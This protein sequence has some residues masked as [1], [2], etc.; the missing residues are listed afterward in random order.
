MLPPPSEKKATELELEMNLNKIRDV[1]SSGLV[2][3]VRALPK[4]ELHLHMDG[5]MRP[6]T[7]YE[8]AVKKGFPQFPDSVNS[9][10]DLAS[11]LVMRDSGDLPEF[12]DKFRFMTPQISGDPEAL[13]RVAFELCEDKN[14]EGV[15]YFETRYAPHLLMSS[16]CLSPT[17]S[18]SPPPSSSPAHCWDLSFDGVVEAVNS[19]L[20]AGESKFGIKA[21]SILCCIRGEDGAQW[22]SHAAQAALKYRGDGVVGIDLAGNESL[23]N[24]G[25]TNEIISAFK[26]AN[27]NQIPITI[28][29]GEA[30]PAINVKQAVE[31]LHAQRI[32]HGYRVLEDPEIYSSIVRQRGIHLEQCPF[33]SV[34]TGAFDLQAKGWPHHPLATFYRDGV[35]FSVNT[36]D[37][38]VTGHSLL[39]EYSN[40]TS[41]SGMRLPLKC[42]VDAIHYAVEASFIVGEEKQQLMDSVEERVRT[43]FAEMSFNEA[44]DAVKSKESAGESAESSKETQYCRLA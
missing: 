40:I 7:L 22:A 11:F 26:Y 36:D 17:P 16:S 8:L 10:S 24:G 20:K 9:A 4:I 3:L 1:A 2:S 13:A 38:T 31:D 6:S 29:A 44:G 5:A 27:D 33:S 41:E 12:L 32:G 15:A 34:K 25:V 39:D 37:P 21:K 28:H 18:S 23:P 43:L 19:G 30:G 42:V 35:S 14:N